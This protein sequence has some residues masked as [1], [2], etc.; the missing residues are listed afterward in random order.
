M[1]GISTLGFTAIMRGTRREKKVMRYSKRTLLIFGLGVLLGLAAFIEES[2]VVEHVAAAV[3]ALGL[4]L[5]PVALLVDFGRLLGFATIAAW[6]RRRRRGSRKP[7]QTRR[8]LAPRRAGAPQTQG[9]LGLVAPVAAL[10][11]G[12]GRLAKLSPRAPLILGS[13]Y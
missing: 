5:L 10:V 1:A 6:L 4:V 7:A 8:N 12:N 9:R 11:C 3:M 2:A 13:A